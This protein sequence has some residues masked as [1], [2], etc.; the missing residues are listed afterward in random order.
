MESYF[1]TLPLE[2]TLDL[3]SLLDKR[4][5][6]QFASVSKNQKNYFDKQDGLWKQIVCRLFHWGTKGKYKIP[7]VSIV[8]T[9]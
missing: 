2:V 5:V 9:T 4:S 6:T 1:S 7:D 3:L 8:I